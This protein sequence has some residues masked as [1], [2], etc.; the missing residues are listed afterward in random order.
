MMKL[1]KEYAAKSQECYTARTKSQDFI[2]SGAPHATGTD[3]SVQGN[4]QE[5]VM[6]GWLV[7]DSGDGMVSQLTA[8]GRNLNASDQDIDLSIF[9]P[10]STVPRF[11]GYQVEG[12]KSISIKGTLDAS[13][14]LSYGWNVS[15]IDGVQ[16]NTGFAQYVF[17][18]G[19]VSVPADG[20]AK[21]KAVSN[22]RTTLGRLVLSGRGADADDNIL[23]TS[24]EV[25]GEEMLAGDGTQEISIKNFLANTH[26]NKGLSLDTVIGGNLPVTISLKNIHATNA[27]TVAGAIVC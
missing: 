25:A 27:I 22:E 20:T 16:D 4:P 13:G 21:L 5:S 18:L 23:I 7:I 17:G 26:D 15:T 3:F 6:L 24:V 9:A 14:S 1:N 12:G 11:C 19:S 10:D 2:L 8:Q